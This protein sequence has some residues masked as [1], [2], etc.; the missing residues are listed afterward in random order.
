MDEDYR[1]STDP[2]QAGV[3]GRVRPV[4]PGGPIKRAL[5]F[6]A[7][8]FTGPSEIQHDQPMARARQIRTRSPSPYALDTGESDPHDGL[9]DFN[10]LRSGVPLTDDA[11]AESGARGLHP[12]GRPAPKW[13]VA[14]KRQKTHQAV[15]PGL[16]ACTNM[17]HSVRTSLEHPSRA[18]DPI[19]CSATLAWRP[20]SANTL[21]LLTKIFWHRCCNLCGKVA[22]CPISYHPKRGPKSSCDMLSGS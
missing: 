20:E 7:D 15:T 16:S 4:G 13:G 10:G 14:S 6:C 12:R 18:C 2:L 5:L 1:R 19:W 8:P 21:L 17:G 11:P 22:G 3:N 9:R